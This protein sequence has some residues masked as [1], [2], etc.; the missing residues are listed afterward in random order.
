MSLFSLWNGFEALCWI[1]SVRWCLVKCLLKIQATLVV[2]TI[3]NLFL[4]SSI[5]WLQNDQHLIFRQN[6][7]TPFLR[8]S[9]PLALWPYN[10]SLQ[11]VDQESLLS[12][13]RVKRYTIWQKETGLICEVLKSLLIWA[14]ISA[15]PQLISRRNVSSQSRFFKKYK[16]VLV[17]LL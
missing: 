4:N 9:F 10:L 7:P 12:N 1:T 8:N 5:Q 13:S 6:V 11:Y 3:K 14:H 17:I 15:L 16:W 2:A